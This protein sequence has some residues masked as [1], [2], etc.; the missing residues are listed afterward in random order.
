MV[1]NDIV[2]NT[3]ITQDDYFNVGQKSKDYH[4]FEAKK[5]LESVTDRI[6]G[7]Q[8]QNTALFFKFDLTNFETIHSRKIYDYIEMLGEIGGLFGILQFVFQAFI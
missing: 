8:N 4:Y 3:I 2:L 7:G 1:Y 6:E 5:N